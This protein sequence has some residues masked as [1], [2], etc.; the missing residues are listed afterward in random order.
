[1]R[2]QAEVADWTVVGFEAVDGGPVTLPMRP[3]TLD[4]MLRAWAEA[5][6]ALNPPTTEVTAHGPKVKT[7]EKF[8][9]FQDVAAGELAP[10]ALPQRLHGRWEELAELERGLGRIFA[11]EQITHGDLRPDNMI[12][13]ADRAWVC[14]WNR[15]RYMPPWIDT[16]NLLTVAQGDGHDADRLFW[17]HPTAR[18]VAEEELDTALAAIT[19]A[20]LQAWPEA[21]QRT[22]SPA[23]KD[24]MR[25]AGAATA[26]WLGRRRGW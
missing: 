7:A 8:T 23:I 3:E 12:A 25:W 21:P 26:E 22:V 11:T 20:L 19:G 18:K 10:F 4:L 17:A 14:D 16:V 6:E 5:V 9:W 24:H 1:M 13:G 2:F 15:L